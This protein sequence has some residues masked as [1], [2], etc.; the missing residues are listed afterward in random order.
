[1][2][3]G[4]LEFD[5]AGGRY[6]GGLLA[7]DMELLALRTK[8]DFLEAGGKPGSA[9]PKKSPAGASAKTDLGGAPGA[10]DTSKLTPEQGVDNIAQNVKALFARPG[11][12][13]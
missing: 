2:I 12:V 7:E 11:N 5:P 8:S 10:P 13:S 4:G 9:P 1:M 3:Y 6:R